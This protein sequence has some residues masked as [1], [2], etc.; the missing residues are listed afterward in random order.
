MT[1]RITRAMALFGVAGAVAVG[2]AGI[3]Q[4]SHGADD[5][6]GHHRHHERHHHHHHHHHRHGGDDGPNHG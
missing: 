4:A 6:A 2:G 1:K 5:P 3:A